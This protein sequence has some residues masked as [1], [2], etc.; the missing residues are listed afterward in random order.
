[1]SDP[2]GV[3]TSVAPLSPFA[4]PPPP[5][6][7]GAVMSP[8]RVPARPKIG[9][10]AVSLLLSVLTASA[11][12]AGV[13]RSLAAGGSPASRRRWSS[14]PPARPVGCCGAATSS[15][16]GCPT[17]RTAAPAVPARPTAPTRAPTNT[18]VSRR[19]A[20]PLHQPGLVQPPGC[21]DGGLEAG[22]EGRDGRRSAARRRGIEVPVGWPERRGR[23]NQ[24]YG[25]SL[26]YTAG[27]EPRWAA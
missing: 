24:W 8:L 13:Q 26:Y 1:M 23:V 2:S 25:F 16:A 5:H 20:T 14:P 12:Y 21:A 19:W 27:L 9:F 6:R 3:D 7:R 15:A 11:R 17:A 10:V 4:E 18:G 22:P